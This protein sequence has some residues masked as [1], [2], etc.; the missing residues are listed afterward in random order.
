MKTSK[1]LHEEA[2]T[3]YEESLVAW[4]KK[5]AIERQRLLLLAFDLERQAAL[6][7]KDR[8]DLEPTRS[9]VFASAAAMAKQADLYREAEQMIGYAL[10]GNPKAYLRDEMIDMLEDMNFQRHLTTSGV[11]LEKDVLRFSVASGNALIRG[12]AK[13]NE[14]LHR[15]ESISH[16]Y[17]KT[18][19]RLSGIPY[20]KAASISNQSAYYL[21]PAEAASY[22]LVMKFTRPDTTEELP[23]M[24][25]VP[26]NIDEFLE[27]ITLVNNKKYKELS[28]RIGSPDYFTN[29]V[30]H[31]KKIAPDG[32]EVKMVGF[33]IYRNNEEKIFKFDRKKSDI[34]EG[35][36]E[37]QESISPE[38]SMSITTLEGRLVIADGLKNHIHLK[39][40][41]KKTYKIQ[42]ANEAQKDIVREYYSE[43]VRIQVK[44]YTENK[45][46]KF[47]FIDIL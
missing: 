34:E 35:I 19:R 15:V 11:I 17:T 28:D 9:N 43:D 31:A 10:S 1:E 12:L 20:K 38:L 16:L 36:N 39:G 7:L 40:D 24:E 42:I 18:D 32:E 26:K 21:S 5:N 4:Y 25:T 23:G 3:L 45:E 30:H 27:C 47:E 8:F 29:F 33:T 14:I 44:Q 41:D 22:A 13:G 6:M 2:M 37:L 46:S